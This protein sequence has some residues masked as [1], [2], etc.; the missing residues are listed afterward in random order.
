[1]LQ[2]LLVRNYVLIDSLEICFPKGLVIITGQT[3]AGKSILMGALSLIT[4][5][6]TDF[7]VISSSADSCTVEAEFVPDNGSFDPEL[8]LVV[9]DAGADWDDG[10]LILRRSISRNGRSRAFV[11]DVPVTLQVLGDLSSRLIDIHSQH[12][13]LKLSDNAFQRSVLDLFAGNGKLLE[14]CSARYR[15]LSS[16]K[17]ER[18]ELNEKMDRLSADR[19]YTEARLKQLEDASLKSG[20]LEELE[21]EQKILANAEEIKGF[22]CSSIDMFDG[23][24][25]G[26]SSVISS[27]R[28]MEKML[29]KVSSLVPSLK[30]IP[31]RLSAC[32]I[33]LDDIYSEISAAN[34]SIDISEGRLDEVEGRISELYSLMHRFSCRSV[35]ELIQLREKLSSSLSD[36]EDLSSKLDSLTVEINRLDKELSDVAA[37]LHDARIKAKKGFASSVMESL[38]FMELGGSKFEIELKPVEIGPSGGDEVH[39]L[40]S[41]TGE[42]PVDI[43]Q[44]AS[45]GELSRIMLA[46]KNVMASY[47]Q[48]PT[49][50]FDEID[51][52]VSGSAADRMGA[53]V[54]GMG[55]RMQIFAITHLPQVAAKG[56]AHYLVSKSA[57][58]ENRT[59]TEIRKLTDDERILEVARM[60]SGS[61]LTDAAV[62]NAKSLMGLN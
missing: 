40:F 23:G 9:E 4:G 22:L 25:G 15:L 39:F 48:M 34:A 35:D 8:R 7:S 42:S 19:E 33:E 31:E 26:N 36:T 53:M 59:V 27:V 16:L 38:S 61:T 21:A 17:S 6:R 43:R 14:T 20:E 56:N 44:C 50:V 10:S 13:T 60:L 37:S 58:A 12:Q 1:M 46:L 41:S 28:D 51:T 3:G 49:M 57:G 32:R 29:T 62:A 47:M 55:E 52:G 30:E 45:G 24:N 5:S 54:C 11:N 2:R 18:R